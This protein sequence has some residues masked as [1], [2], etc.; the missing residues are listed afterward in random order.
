MHAKRLVAEAQA[1]RGMVAQTG[2]GL[3]LG[4]KIVW[5]TSASELVK[6]NSLELGAGTISFQQRLQLAQKQGIT[7]REFEK[8]LA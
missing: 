6:Y 2:R 7:L 8:L 5:K 4:P 1:M 3:N